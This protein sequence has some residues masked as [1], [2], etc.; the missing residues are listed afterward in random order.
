MFLLVVRKVLLDSKTLLYKSSRSKAVFD[1][2][3][4]GNLCEPVRLCSIHCLL[5]TSWLQNL[6]QAWKVPGGDSR[7]LTTQVSFNRKNPYLLASS[8]VNQV[9]IWDMRK[10]GTFIA[11]LT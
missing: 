3:V 7:V 8:Q 5:L 2:F 6:V 11:S 9:Y 10:V 4:L 1:R